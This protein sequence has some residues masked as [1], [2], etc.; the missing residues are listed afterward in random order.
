MRRWIPD[1]HEL[2]KSQ[3]LKPFAKHLENDALW[4]SNRT[5]VERAVG[6]GLFFGLLL[7][8]GQFVFAIAAAVVLRAHLGIAAASTLIT[9]PLTFGPV[10]WL[11]YQLGLR[12]TGGSVTVA[13]GSALKQADSVTTFANAVEAAGWPLAVG[14][15]TFALCGALVGPLLVRLLWRK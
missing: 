6:I 8:V 13:T 11:A 4:V 10:Y 9:N 2:A 12:L 15:V 1:R 3:W 14:L 5:T 7:P